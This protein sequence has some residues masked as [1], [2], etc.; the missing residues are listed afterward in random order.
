M[1]PSK[2]TN[3]KDTTHAKQSA[4]YATANMD[5]FLLKGRP[6]SSWVQ[7]IGIVLIGSACLAF[8]LVFSYYAIEDRS[9]V[10]GGMAICYIAFGV[11][12]L[13]RKQRAK[14]AKFIQGK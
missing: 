3:L 11:R 13:I 6:P 10:V 1:N 5:E 4:R 7:I 9:I 2:H 8:G 12:V 14:S